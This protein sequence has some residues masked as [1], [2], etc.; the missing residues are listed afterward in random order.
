MVL[1]QYGLTSMYST[2]YLNQQRN[3]SEDS[4]FQMPIL[5]ATPNPLAVIRSHPIKAN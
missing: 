5:T 1:L 3:K 4:V 2:Y